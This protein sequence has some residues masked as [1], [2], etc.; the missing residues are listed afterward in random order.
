MS[1][2][3]TQII[4][5]LAYPLSKLS[6]TTALNQTALIELSINNG[7]VWESRNTTIADFGNYIIT[8]HAIFNNLYDLYNTSPDN[9]TFTKPTYFDNRPYVK[10]ITGTV[11]EASITSTLS[12]TYPPANENLVTWYDVKRHINETGIAVQATGANSA[13]K[14]YVTTN[15]GMWVSATKPTVTS[16]TDYMEPIYESTNCVPLSAKAIGDATL[17]GYG[18][19]AIVAEKDMMVNVIANILLTT[20]YDE[21]IAGSPKPYYNHNASHWLALIINGDDDAPIVASISQ[22]TDIISVKIESIKYAIAQVKL[23]MPIAKNTTF[24]LY[25]PATVFTN[26]DIITD[27]KN[28]DRFKRSLFAGVNSVSISYFDTDLSTD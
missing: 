24:Y 16:S 9:I 8:S 5:N 22:F 21:L 11:S 6:T 14:R 7:G 26:S 28:N 1:T 25:T 13:Y 27:I 3:Q 10:Q 23:T 18:T 20:T 4:R 2:S 12:E 19:Q 15:N 17:I